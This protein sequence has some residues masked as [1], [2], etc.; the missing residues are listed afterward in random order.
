MILLATKALTPSHNPAWPQPWTLDSVSLNPMILICVLLPDQILKVALWIHLSYFFR[1]DIFR[2][3]FFGRWDDSFRAYV[4]TAQA[5]PC[6]L[7]ACMFASAQTFTSRYQSIFTDAGN[8]SQ[9]PIAVKIQ[10]I[11]LPFTERSI[12]FVKM[13][14]A[15]KCRLNESQYHNM[16]TRGSRSWRRQTVKI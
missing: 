15:E 1:A 6:R 2:V 8:R 16:F 7:F 5:M 10:K 12:S 13:I 3:M 14:E 11:S 4:F 9:L